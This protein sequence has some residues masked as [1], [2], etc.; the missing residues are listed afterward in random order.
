LGEHD[1]RVD[2]EFSS[3]LGINSY[4]KNFAVAE[5]ISHPDYDDYTK[6]NDIAL[7]RLSKDV[8][9]TREIFYFFAN[10]ETGLY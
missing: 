6:Q 7:I 2:P 8:E 1:T 10:E 4:V 3:E 9:F 5:I